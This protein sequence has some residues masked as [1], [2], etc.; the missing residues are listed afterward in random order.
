M[1]KENL[2]K[3]QLDYYNGKPAFFSSDAEPL[4]EG[5]RV[6]FD[7]EDAEGYGKPY[8]ESR[9]VTGTVGKILSVGKPYEAL[10]DG[11]TYKEMAANSHMVCLC[12][13][14]IAQSDIEIPDPMVGVVEGGPADWLPGLDK[15]D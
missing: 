8:D 12:W 4:R 1:K 14:E 2:R 6:K 3:V 7:L 10:G 11:E 15:M 9:V 5:E 13:A